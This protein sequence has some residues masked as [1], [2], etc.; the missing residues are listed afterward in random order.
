MREIT[1]YWSLRGVG[2]GEG[3]MN[4]PASR[5]NGILP[6]SRHQ[7][8]DLYWMGR[9]WHENQMIAMSVGITRSGNGTE[10]TG[11]P[12]PA[13][14]GGG[15]PPLSNYLSIAPEW[16]VTDIDAI[17]HMHTALLFSISRVLTNICQ[18]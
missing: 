17:L 15:L 14:G 18:C 4:P 6:L 8:L 9:C 11:Q 7:P 12:A 16:N 10:P 13:E 2:N 3:Q 1:T 5:G